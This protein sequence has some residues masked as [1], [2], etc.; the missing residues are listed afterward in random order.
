M[1]TAAALAIAARQDGPPVPE[2]PSRFNEELQ[3]KVP[4]Y[5]YSVTAEGLN[6]QQPTAATPS[7]ATTAAVA[8]A[9]LPTLA[10]ESAAHRIWKTYC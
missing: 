6:R 5:R 2:N 9:A 1:R 3:N 7:E 8:A 4:E 10:N